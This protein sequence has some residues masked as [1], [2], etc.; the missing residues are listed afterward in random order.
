GDVLQNPFYLKN[1]RQAASY[2]FDYQTFIDEVIY[3]H[4]VQGRGPVPM[5]MFGHDDDALQYN[6]SI[7]DAV[8]K[9][10]AAMSEGLDDILDNC[11]YTID[12]YYNSGNE[13]RRKGMLLLRDGLYEVLNETSQSP[14]ED[15]SINVQGVEWSTYIGR[16]ISGDMP[17]FMIGWAPD[18]ADPDNYVTPY[19]H[20][21][22][23]Y[24]GFQ[25]IADS[26][27]WDAEEVDGWISDAA[28][29]QD[30]DERIEL[31]EDIQAEI[32][33]HAAYI[34]VYQSTVFHV[35]RAEMNGYQYNPM[36]DAYFFH[37]WKLE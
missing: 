36:H 9:W 4:G 3:G 34:W 18:Y 6:Y 8:A 15:V 20:S 1:L 2:A 25:R 23:T 11:S 16:L 7:D 32:I 33:E 17:A 21:S 37:Y 19:V 10:D 22:G 12:L 28:Q 26:P 30:D 24:S 35:E 5:G 14:S 31:Y 29:S 27:G 13:V